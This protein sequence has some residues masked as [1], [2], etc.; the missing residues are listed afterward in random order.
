M[1]RTKG[2]LVGETQTIHANESDL[3]SDSESSRASKKKYPRNRIVCDPSNRQDIFT[4]KIRDCKFGDQAAK[5]LK[6]LSSVGSDADLARSQF[7]IKYEETASD[8]D[9]QF[10]SRLENGIDISMLFAGLFSAVNTAFII[11]M[12]FSIVVVNSS[13][14]AIANIANTGG[15]ALS[16]A[17]ATEL[18]YASLSTSL[19]SAFGTLLAK[20]WLA[21]FKATRST[22]GSLSSRGLHR[23]RKFDILQDWHFN[24]ILNCFP[25]LLRGSLLLFAI[26]L[27]GNTWYPYHGVAGIVLAATGVGVTLYLVTF[28]AAMLSP[29]SPFQATLSQL[30]QQFLNGVAQ[31]SQLPRHLRASS[32][33]PDSKFI[34]L[35][36]SALS[37]EA[38]AVRWLLRISTDPAVVT[39]VAKMVPEVDWPVD[40]DVSEFSAPLLETF[41]SCFKVESNECSAVSISCSD[42]DR[43]YACGKALFHLYSEALYGGLKPDLELRDNLALVKLCLSYT[44][45][46]NSPQKRSFD[47]ICALISLITRDSKLITP[48]SVPEAELSWVSHIIPAFLYSRNHCRWQAWVEL[49]ASVIPKFARYEPMC[50]KVLADHWVII[51]LIIGMPINPDDLVKIDKSMAIARLREEVCGFIEPGPPRCGTVIQKTMTTDDFALALDLVLRVLRVERDRRMIAECDL[52]SWVAGLYGKLAIGEDNVW[53]NN[54]C[55]IINVMFRTVNLHS[56]VKG[57]KLQRSSKHIHHILKRSVESGDAETV[58]LV[59]PLWLDDS[60]LQVDQD[61]CLDA[62]TLLLGCDS[63][64]LCHVAFHSIP[65]VLD[66]SS[67]HSLQDLLQGD[68]SKLVR[69]FD[70]L[71]Y[72]LRMVYAIPASSLADWDHASM[73]TEDKLNTVL[74]YLRVV[75]SMADN[76]FFHGHLLT[77]GHVERGM[78]IKLGTRALT[79]ARAETLHREHSFLLLSIVASIGTCSN[80]CCIE[81]TVH[82]V[83]TIIK[84]YPLEWQTIIS[85]LQYVQ[86]T[87]RDHLDESH[88]ARIA[89]YIE[90]ICRVSHDVPMALREAIE[91]I[92]ARIDLTYTS[93]FDSALMRLL[94]ALGSANTPP[95]PSEWSSTRTLG[96]RS[97]VTSD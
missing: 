91:P 40:F 38:P 6:S 21:Q 41:K 74:G 54:G 52:D 69:L 11:A 48:I 58:G 28:F 44:K 80:L 39:A 88:I 82:P 15:L 70:T 79:A 81:A 59:L 37:A 7:W 26:S 62:I 13:N 96:S 87:F 89:D 94:Q 10:V 78:D 45:D 47:F 72:P 25:A 73:M 14:A 18:S 33:R 29:D 50:S 27:M 1:A 5:L 71:L 97:G 22:Y 75:L 17:W 67:P 16:P 64:R 55:A 60:Q 31:L 2:P 92:A 76:A 20:Q 65:Q 56:L 3:E 95:P 63:P 42:V 83:A 9:A 32:S 43:A 30:L 12:Q 57:V 34:P 61:L 36:M 66:P 53:E 4:S 68:E 23:Q 24:F 49:A 93:A 8:F 84:D 86:N 19:L 85:A 77:R 51:A 46:L 90:S 35:P